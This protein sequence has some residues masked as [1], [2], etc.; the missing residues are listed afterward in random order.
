MSPKSI[1][2]RRHQRAFQLRDLVV[3]LATLVL[4]LSMLLSTRASGRG[5][6]LAEMCRANMRRLAQAWLMYADDNDGRQVPNNG[7]TSRQTWANGWLTLSTSSPDN[8]NTTFLVEPGTNG[9]SGLLGPYLD[10]DA[11]VFRC[12]ADASTTTIGGKHYN[13]VRSVSMSNWMGG[14]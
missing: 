14:G 4:L 11:S 5:A 1:P 2:T 8:T 13:R 10:R 6:S 12:P 9:M 7:N 3:V